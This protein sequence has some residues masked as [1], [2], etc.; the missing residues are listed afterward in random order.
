MSSHRLRPSLRTS[1][2]MELAQPHP[3][4]CRGGPHRQASA[5]PHKQA[6]GT[7]SPHEPPH[8]PAQRR[9]PPMAA[10]LWGGRGR[11]R[12]KRGCHQWGP[13]QLPLLAPS[14]S[15]TDHSA[16]SAASVGSAKNAPPRSRARMRESGDA[17]PV[18]AGKCSSCSP[19]P[20]TST[21][22]E[23]PTGS[24]SSLGRPFLNPHTSLT[25]RQR[26]TLV[27]R[28]RLLLP[29][30]ASRPRMT[31]FGSERGTGTRSGAIYQ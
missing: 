5:A 20:L 3:L 23:A 18:L 21:A 11:S 17:P 7:R 19:S 13:P 30:L 31:S 25:Q 2:L 6:G 28:A 22:P 9:P 29:S 8:P 24:C 14:L 12:P 15:S 4:D 27:L 26:P 1:T 10:M 16:A